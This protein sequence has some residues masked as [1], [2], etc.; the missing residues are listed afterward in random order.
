MPVPTALF[1]EVRCDGRGVSSG[2]LQPDALCWS[3][4]A[5]F[6]QIFWNILAF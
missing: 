5:Q 6:G 2:V 3:M 1:E 4:P